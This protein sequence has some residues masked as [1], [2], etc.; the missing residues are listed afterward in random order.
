MRYLIDFEDELI[1]K[2]MFE[3]V[4]PLGNSTEHY[5]TNIQKLLYS[6]LLLAQW[7]KYQAVHGR[8]HGIEILENLCKKNFHIAST[9][10]AKLVNQNINNVT[11]DLKLNKLG[12]SC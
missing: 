6:N 10:K 1:R 9:Y 11:S 8:Q 12:I 2:G 4:F 7:Q 5:L 3:L